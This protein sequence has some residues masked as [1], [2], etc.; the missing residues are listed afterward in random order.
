MKI[1]VLGPGC[2]SC[3]QVLENAISATS[4]FDSSLH[5]HVEKVTDIKEFARRGVFMT[6]GLVIDGEI[7]SVGRVLSVEEIRKAIEKKVQSCRT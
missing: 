4:G 3:E 6:P 7:V 2:K 1:E 5:I